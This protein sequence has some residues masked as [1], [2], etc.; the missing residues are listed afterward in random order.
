[1]AHI[2]P[3]RCIDSQTAGYSEMELYKTAA[4]DLLLSGV[5]TLGPLFMETPI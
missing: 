3:P 5:L 2:A 4:S 1:M